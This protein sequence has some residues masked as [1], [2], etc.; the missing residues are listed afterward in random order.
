M[1]AG[2]P[3]AAAE[4]EAAQTSTEFFA[5]LSGVLVGTGCV[6]FRELG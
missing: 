2:L 3:I 6:V 5:H 4:T 1:V